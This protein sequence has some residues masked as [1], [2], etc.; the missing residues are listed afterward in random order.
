MFPLLIDS[1]HRHFHL[2]KLLGLPV[3]RWDE[4]AVSECAVAA[5]YRLNLLH[6]P[7]HQELSAEQMDWMVQVV[8]QVLNSMG[9]SQ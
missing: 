4:M 6:L 3:W 1:P 8:Q 2:L 5:K 7:C 9:H